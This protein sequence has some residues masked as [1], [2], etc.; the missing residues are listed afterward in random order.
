MFLIIL[1][2]FLCLPGRAVIEAP[3]L[4]A[5][6]DQ[7]PSSIQWRHIVTEHFDVIF[8]EEIEQKARTAA[9]LLEKAY[10][11]VAASLEVKPKKIPLVLQ[12][13]SIVSNGFVSLGPRRT[14][15]N[16]TPSIDPE[17]TNTEWI[18]TLAI[19]EFRHVVQFQ[20][21]RQGFNRF[22]EVLFGEVGQALGL[23]LTLP[24]WFLEGDAVGI[25]TA[26]TDGGRGRL[27]LFERDLR[28][29]LL[30]GKKFEY[31]KAHLGSYKDY[32]PSHYV[33]GY[34]YTSYLR[35]KYGDLFL[36]RLTDQSASRSY[37][38]LTFYNAVDRLTN[39]DFEDFYRNVMAD[40]L[41]EWKVKADQLTLTEVDVKNKKQK[42]GWTN[43]LYPQETPTG[44]ILALKRG[45]SFIDQFVLLSGKKEKTI[46]YPGPL[47]QEYPYKLRKGK[48][49]F[50]EAEVHPR[51]GLLDYSRL[52]VF[53]L[54]KK[55][56]TLDLRR[57]K[58]RL[59]VLDHDGEKILMAEWDEKQNQSLVVLD[60][61]GALI[62]RIRFPSSEVITS[63]DWINDDEVVMVLK[64]SDDL[65]S[66]VKFSFSSREQLTLVEKGPTNLGFL[67][68][69]AEDIFFESPSS[70][71][72]NI[73]RYNS[74]GNTQLTSSRFGAYAPALKEGKL[75]YNDYS[76]KGMNVAVKKLELLEEQK[77][78]NSFVPVYQKFAQS[79]KS[80]ELKTDLAGGGEYKVSKYS[81]TK[82]AINLHSWVLLAPPLS[83]TLT[84]V[85][86][87]RDVLG[88]LTLTSGA[89]YD[90]NERVPLGFV[91]A[92][93]SYYYPLVDFR[94]AFG[95]RRQSFFF[96]PELVE[97]KWE[98]GT[99][100]LGVSLPWRLISGR[101]LQS[102]TLRAFSKL[103]KVNNK[104]AFDPTE[105]SDSTLH[106][107]GIEFLY[108]ITSRGARRD[109]L[110][111]L[112]FSLGA[113]FQKGKDITGESQQGRIFS[114]DSRLY[115]PGL[116][117]HH[118]FSQQFAFEHQ[119]DKNYQY[120]S[121][122]LYPRG[123]RNLFLQELTKYSANY[124]LPLA[125]PDWNLSRYIY[126]KRIALNLFYDELN[127]RYQSSRYHAASTGWE[128]VF[129]TNLVRIFL[130]LNLGLRGSYIL[131]GEEKLE[132]YEIFISSILNTF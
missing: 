110:P 81:L 79:E 90:L 92:T 2:F 101:F 93:W 98:E 109:I 28:A 19:H 117:R 89:V 108:D 24:P 21:T 100:E 72:D 126:L 124:T 63:L 27:P 85:G 16:V 42:E 5:S 36:S 48:L 112:G 4:A 95:G 83:P 15:W 59:A 33:Y 29:L 12:N 86:I 25:E 40:L 76:A 71:I 8:P 47:A 111:P 20:K 82:N 87:S 30:S 37:N 67:S 106:S 73:W 120:S 32:V 56:V 118:S 104:I 78:E 43:Y 26:L 11:Y 44:E 55:K 74:L 113:E 66:L 46:F 84:V 61:K 35:N 1:T 102:F 132:N 22:Y 58:A 13:Q 34:F 68:S 115:L 9:Y 127:G 10:P 77:S 60:H 17:L 3:Y 131:H 64:G 50:L 125:Y 65:K 116:W 105:V 88:N 129:E 53:D 49:A 80:A 38:P 6:A 39:E 23:G 52:K 114:A 123:T 69:S 54:K 7:N 103:I 45:L 70:G 57:L 99:L 41:K 62:H 31:D 107:P 91:S 51:W 18:K 97:D 96:G 122:V 14:E 119:K 75:L 130:P 121:I 94:A 128:T